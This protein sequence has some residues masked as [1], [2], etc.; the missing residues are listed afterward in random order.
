M[1]KSV[2]SYLTTSDCGIPSCRTFV[3]GYVS[4]N[5]FLTKG[6]IT[7]KHASENGCI[8]FTKNKVRLW[9]DNL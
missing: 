4:I 5:S 3:L 7:K 2:F 9:A 6:N 1:C 8:F